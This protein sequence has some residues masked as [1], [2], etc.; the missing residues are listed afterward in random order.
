[1]QQTSTYSQLRRLITVANKTHLNLL[2]I[3]LPATSFHESSFQTQIY[4][5]DMPHIFL[6][7]PLK[8]CCFY[9]TRI[10]PKAQLNFFFPLNGLKL[11]LLR[12][13]PGC[14]FNIRKSYDPLKDQ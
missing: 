8:S 14:P 13:R 9:V 5:I 4:A 6:L 11:N 3:L 10:C 2:P 1:M 12:K 7:T